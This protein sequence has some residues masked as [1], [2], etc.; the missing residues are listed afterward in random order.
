MMRN[1]MDVIVADRLQRHNESVGDR[2]EGR[3]LGGRV[4][5]AGTRRRGRWRRQEKLTTAY[6]YR[7]RKA[8][9]GYL[10]HCP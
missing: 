8:S 1:L 3:V 10:L 2:I 7:L 4:I 6:R 5:S 9:A